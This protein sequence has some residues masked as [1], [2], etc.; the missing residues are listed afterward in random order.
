MSTINIHKTIIYI[1]NSPRW[2]VIKPT[3]AISSSSTL[4]K[5]EFCWPTNL[6]F[7]NWGT[8]PV[9]KIIRADRLL[10]HL[11]RGMEFRST[12]TQLYGPPQWCNDGFHKPHDPLF[13]MA[14]S[15]INIYKWQCSIVTI[16]IGTI[17]HS[18]IGV[19]WTPTERY[20]KRGPTLQLYHLFIW[21]LS[22]KLI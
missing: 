1:Y 2:L 10:V 17:N 9:E 13:S 3:I 4:V 15:T 19:M 21:D 6:A 18:D 12:I 11:N 8:T 16:V 14:K 5:L 20:R 7:T 22:D